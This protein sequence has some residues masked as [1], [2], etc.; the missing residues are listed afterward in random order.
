MDLKF[1][2]SH[3]SPN[4]NVQS[5]FSGV[6]WSDV[7]R[8]I[9]EEAT[10]LK[11]DIFLWTGC[12]F[13]YFLMTF[14][15]NYSSFLLVIIS[16]EKFFALYFPLQTKTVCTVSM[17]RK[18]SLVTGITF[19]GFD[20]QYFFITKKFEDTFG[21][22]CY[23]GNVSW[24]YLSILFS[25]VDAT[26]YSYLPFSIM[27]FTNFA[28]IYKFVHVKWRNR[29]GNTESTSQALSKSATRG[30]AMLLTV[31][32]A[33]I[34]LTSPIM[35]A[36]AVWPNST[37]PILIF[38]S[39]MAIQYL[40]H[41]INGILYCIVGSRFRNELKNLFSCDKKDSRF[42]LSSHTPNTTVNRTTSMKQSVPTVSTT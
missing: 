10:D 21:D 40:N 34:I 11:L 14:G 5:I 39:L 23:Y 15:S 4:V 20:L 7:L 1:A 30:T 16:L 42:P 36:N 22:Y 38:K 13:G 33:F 41:G 18:V 27:L 31:S 3:V 25:I 8:R 26:L 29:R 2:F 32:F 9:V 17:A 24:K 6:L 19:I 12:G 28:I 37:I 35:V